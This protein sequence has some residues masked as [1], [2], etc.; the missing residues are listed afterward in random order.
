MHVLRQ[1]T[2]FAF[3][4]GINTSVDFGI[5]LGLTRFIPYWSQHQ[6]MAAIISVSVATL[7]SYIWNK[8]WT[9]NNTS[10]NHGPVFIRFL[11]ATLLGLGLHS[12]VFSLALHFGV[13]DILAKVSAICVVMAWNFLAY[14]FWAFAKD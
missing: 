8:Q 14:K 6:V 11:V 5:Y 7:N 4:G 10:S 3:V 1:F 12:L 2:K 13:H 9:F